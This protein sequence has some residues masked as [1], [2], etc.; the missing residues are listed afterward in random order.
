MSSFSIQPVRSAADLEATKA[1]FNA[2]AA[3]LGVNLTY[4]KFAEEMAVMPGKYAPPKGE[5]LLARGA[6]GAALGCVGL[7]PLEDAGTCEMK[8]LYVTPEG[9]GLGLGK[10]LAERV[11]EE[12]RRIGYRQMLLDT[13]PSLATAVALYDRMGFARIPAYYDTPIPGTIFMA[14]SL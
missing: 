14:L 4:Q 13:L 1:L 11:V 5:L 9:R 6:D 10:A 2:Y 7:R 3:S 12:A 8:R